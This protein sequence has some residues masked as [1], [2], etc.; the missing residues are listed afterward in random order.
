MGQKFRGAGVALITPFKEDSTV[1]YDALGNLIEEMISGGID[2][3]VVLGTTAETAT[4]SKE[5][6]EKVIDFAVEKNAGRLP[7]VVGAGGNN[8]LEVVESLK[9]LDANKIDGILSVVPYYS[10]PTQ[11]GIYQHFM[12]IAESSPVPIILYN[13]PGR[14]GVH[15]DAATTLRLAN[16]SN[17]FVAIKEASGDLN[18]L[19]LILRDRLNNFSVLSGD[20]GLT[21]PAISLGA[22]GVISVVAN[23]FPT[24]VANMVHLA[25]EGDFRKASSLHLR[26]LNLFNLLFVEGNPGGIKAAL[27]VKGKVQNI[28]RL[29]LTTISEP[30]YREI[31]EEIKKISR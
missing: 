14:T 26:F 13:V 7:I 29:P 17:K 28:L 10:K 15:M 2:F 12:Q 11:E 23:G 9:N 20:D 5:E 21:V 4:L 3:L 18:E 25:A 8:T 6:K 30:T 22:D 16:A 1:D 27:H 19:A 24:E 31:A